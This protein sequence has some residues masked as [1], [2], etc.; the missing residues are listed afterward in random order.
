M[1]SLFSSGTDD[2]GEALPAFDDTTA[3]TRGPKYALLAGAA[4]LA[5]LAG[6]G[7]GLFWLASS[8][9]ADASAVAVPTSPVQDDPSS[10]STTDPTT[11]AVLT[12]REIVVAPEVEGGGSGATPDATTSGAQPAAATPTGSVSTSA[13]SSGSKATTAPSTGKPT[14]A[15]PKPSGGGVSTPSPSRSTAAPWQV[16]TVHFDGIDVPS[17]DGAGSFILDSKGV[18]PFNTFLASGQL[19]PSTSTVYSPVGS[20]TTRAMTDDEKKACKDSVRS[21]PSQ[22]AADT[23]GRQTEGCTTVVD[24]VWAP[25]LV[26]SS[27][28]VAG[29]QASAGWVLKEDADVP[30]AALGKVSGTV[31][32]LA[33]RQKSALFQVDNHQPVWV[34]EN[35][36]VPGTPLTY[37][38]LQLDAP[39]RSGIAVFTASD[40]NTYF[41]AMGGG[42]ASGITF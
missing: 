6:G 12:S 28:A 18:T 42:E 16:G 26:R 3:S 13:P 25:V 35:D 11:G 24:S 36:K 23:I 2:Q 8:P 10:S 21:A 32:F 14:T 33:A 22:D 29:G 15:T 37:T 17:P 34:L 40:G 4:A 1:S 20:V 27:Q 30:A 9:A 38:G 31:R 39:K 41:T 5:V 7:G 19:I